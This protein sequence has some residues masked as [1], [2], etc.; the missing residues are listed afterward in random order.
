MILL[1]AGG[2]NYSDKEAVYTALDTLHHGPYPILVLITGGCTGAD[3]LA[4]SWAFENGIQVLTFMA[5]WH[6]YGK[7]AGPLRNAKMI[8]EAKALDKNQHLPMPSEIHALLF[9]GGNGT[10]DMARQLQRAR[11]PIISH[12]ETQEPDTLFLF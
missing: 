1:V 11:I 6:T 7:A 10:L 8:R 3:S 4:S 2:R 5:D 12:K 9:P